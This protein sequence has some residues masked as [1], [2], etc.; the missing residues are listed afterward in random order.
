MEV[1]VDV[2]GLDELIATLG[3]LGEAIRDGAH[4]A[5]EDGALVIHKATVPLIP[6]DTGD[7]RATARVEVESDGSVSVVVGNANVGY[8]VYVHENL[9][10]YH[11]SGQAKF[12][13]AAGLEVV[14]SELVEK[15]IVKRAYEEMKTIVRK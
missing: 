12:L 9:T 15:Q 13:E 6:I 8:A 3:L 1:T 7:L 4:T 14:H 5:L 11:A 10:A 2:K